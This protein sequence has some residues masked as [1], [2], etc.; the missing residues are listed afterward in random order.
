MADRTLRSDG[1]QDRQWHFRKEVTVGTLLAVL[2][3]GIMFII[4]VTELRGIT[5]SNTER[6]ARIEQA[7]ER[8][9]VLEA[10]MAAAERAAERLE[11]RTVRSL[12][13]IKDILQRME[14][15]QREL[16]GHSR[17]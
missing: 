17:P 7:P 16:D 1:V 14:E 6:I 2:A 9:A 10:R 13:E 4:T 5:S 3:Y 15:R 8:V 12:S 11:A